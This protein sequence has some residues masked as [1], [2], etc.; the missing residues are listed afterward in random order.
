[1]LL[2]LPPELLGEVINCLSVPDLKQLACVNSTIKHH[3][4]PVLYRSITF[5]IEAH[6]SRDVTPLHSFLQAMIQG[7][8]RRGLVKSLTFT[9]REYPLAEDDEWKSLNPLIP[10]VV[11]FVAHA[12]LQAGFDPTSELLSE[13][14]SGGESS[15]DAAIAF[16]LF[17]LPSLRTIR[18]GLVVSSLG[19]EYMLSLI[20]AMIK[21]LIT[22]GYGDESRRV[23]HQLQTL[24][25]VEFCS[26]DGTYPDQYLADFDDLLWLFY[27]PN[28]QSIKMCAVDDG[29]ELQ[30]PFEPPLRQTLKSLILQDSAISLDTL[31]QLLTASPN[32]KRFEYNYRCDI[33]DPDLVS[34]RFLDCAQLREALEIRASSLEHLTL[35]IDFQNGDFPPLEIEPLHWDNTR[36]GVSGS[37]G[38]MSAFTA[39]RRLEAPLVMLLGWDKAVATEQKLVDHVPNSLH[40]LCCT[41]DMWGSLF[42]PWNEEVVVQQVTSVVMSRKASLQKLFLTGQ[43]YSKIWNES[44][45]KRVRE[46]CQRA[47]VDHK[48]IYRPSRDRVIVTFD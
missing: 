16:L 44:S 17:L 24:S 35:S 28:I 22:T 7:P 26:R 32:L 13:L 18:L 47:G 30:W 29:D 38:D 2:Q 23:S 3:V 15:P 1:M 42:L 8:D 9:S 27:L 20:V 34:Y 43:R 5:T 4:L 25:D 10:R 21:H 41:N 40:E 36:Y 19:D 45:V 14:Q 37:L 6:Q 31:K 39:L 46:A 33:F 48:L 12:L 11:D